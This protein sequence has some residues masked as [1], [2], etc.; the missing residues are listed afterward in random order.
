MKIKL[1]GILLFCSVCL[2][3][4]T[5][6]DIPFIGY[7]GGY[8][9]LR[10]IKNDSSGYLFIPNLDTNIIVFISANYKDYKLFN[11][12]NQLI[13]EGD[14]GG[15][16]FVDYFKRFGKW[17]SYYPE[18]NRPRVI[19]HFHSDMPVGVWNFFYP[20]GQLEKR[21]SVTQVL[22]DSLYWTCKAGQYEEYYETGQLKVSGYYKIV[23]D[24]TN[25]PQPNSVTKN[26]RDSIVVAPVSRPF[27]IWKYFH[28][29][30]EVAK[31][32]EYH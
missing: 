27:G 7:F 5:D 13:V 8:G 14:I 24:T 17:T 16:V 21:F 4:Q 31:I 18:T 32:E 25:L 23:R 15:K 1:C 29:G 26:F 2:F 3:A 22:F 11:R 12:K 28:L 6:E 20:N 10:E 19:G 9:I 30:G